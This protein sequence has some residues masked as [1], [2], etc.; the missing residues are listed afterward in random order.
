MSKLINRC[1]SEF[2]LEYDRKIGQVYLNRFKAISSELRDI[3]TALKGKEEAVR[4]A[5]RAI[6]ERCEEILLESES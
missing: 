1:K 3:H 5:I 6:Q 2:G 4:H